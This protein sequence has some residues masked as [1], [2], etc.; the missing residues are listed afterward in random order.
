MAMV[1]FL[2]LMI[3]EIGFAVFGFTKSTLKNQW[4][5]ERLLVN[6]AEA[7]IFLLLLLL[8]GIDLSFRFTALAILLLIRVLAAGLFFLL[9]RKNENMKKKAAIAGSV[10][11]SILLFAVSLTPAFLFR[12]YTGRAVTGEYEPAYCEA[13]LIDPQ[14]PETFENDGSN[15]EVPV[16]FYYP[17][18]ISAVPEHS[19]P[20]VIFS[21][22]AFG[23]YQSNTSTYQEL[24]SHGYVVV[25]LDHPYHSFF[26]KDSEGKTI[27]ADMEFLQ[28]ALE[29][30]SNDAP[31]SE[32]Y[33]LTSE[34]MALRKADMNFVI[35]E[36]KTAVQTGNPDGQ[37]HFEKD[38]EETILSVLQAVNTEKIGLIG[39]SLG[40]ATAVTVG[41]RAD[42][43]AA[44]DLDGTM[45]G[46]ETGVKNEE[47][48]VNEEAYET[49]LL[50]IDSGSHHQ[51]ME[52]SEQNGYVYVNNV[53]LAHAPQGYEIHIKNAEHMNFTDLPLFSPW[54]AKKLGT[55][56]IDPGAC[57]DQV[58]ALV[59]RFF[60]SY[61]KD[62]GE[63]TAKESY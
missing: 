61:L 13:I 5:G 39:H 26:C 16:H 57:I 47:I 3:T 4:T 30:G 20:L 55:G 50:C 59:L 44:V 11:I 29:I 2:L 46:E 40:G 1:I 9:Y 22:G 28:N 63:F 38:G 14:R 8:P 45:L 36:L 62:A 6:G 23:Y 54:L 15:R 43:S 17:A 31:E 58:N 12:D 48:Q 34:W 32:V 60:D 33:D 18:D 19:L 42:I 49:P 27:I 51:S 35:D 52:I 21:H 41:R 56:S 25:S 37:W 10:L 53:I 7:V 24:A